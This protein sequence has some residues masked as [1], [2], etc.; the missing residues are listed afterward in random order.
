MT[1]PANAPRLPGHAPQLGD[2]NGGSAPS[3]L[4]QVVDMSDYLKSIENPQALKNQKALAAA[5]D[6]AVNELVGENDVQR[7]KKPDRDGKIKEYKKKSAWKKLARHFRIDVYEKSHSVVR[8]EDGNT[9]A[10]V[11]M[12]GVAPWGQRVEEIGACTT[13]EERFKHDKS[14]GWHDCLATAQTR[15]SNRAIS[16]LIAAG[17]VSAEEVEGQRGTAE[18]SDVVT[19]IYGPQQGLPITDGAIGLELL[20]FAIDWCCKEEERKV[21]FEDFVRAAWEILPD[22]IAKCP[23]DQLKKVAKWAA[24]PKREGKFDSLAKECADAIH[25]RG[26]DHEPKP[27]DATTGTALEGQKQEE[28]EQLAAKLNPQP[29]SA[30]GN[31]SAAAASSGSPAAAAAPAPSTPTT[32]V[33]RRPADEAPIEAWRAYARALLTDPSVAQFAGMDVERLD[34]K[35]LKGEISVLEAVLGGKSTEARRSEQGRK[36]QAGDAGEQ[37]EARAS[38]AGEPDRRRRGPVR[39]RRLRRRTRRDRAHLTVF[40]FV[41]YRGA[42]PLDLI[43]AES[44]ADALE[45][46]RVMWGRTLGVAPAKW[47]PFDAFM[48]SYR[49]H[50]AEHAHRKATT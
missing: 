28:A 39:R 14:K 47:R 23:D 13:Y 50:N 29:A 30:E 8:T 12:L 2:E 27:K 19:F 17:E 44:T 37:G 41:V 49:A 6:K 24:S 18:Q 26:L 33:V 34:L 20:V 35:K 46:T 22:K 4:D 15:A 11:I 40:A 9:I 45:M 42:V 3:L 31:A 10:E 36:G 43:A 1:A 5:Y 7:A 38:A 16:A 48:L 32:N 21:K 25:A